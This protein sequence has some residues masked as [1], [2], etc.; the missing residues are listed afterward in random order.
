M[1]AC[2][3]RTALF[4]KGRFAW[5][6]RTWWLGAYARAMSRRAL[7]EVVLAASAFADFHYRLFDV[8]AARHVQLPA[9]ADAAAAPHC[10]VDA[11]LQRRLLEGHERAVRTTDFLEDL[12]IE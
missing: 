1:V 5:V 11:A 7:A 9:R 8:V 10:A 2:A 4:Y 6:R 3:R 12:Y